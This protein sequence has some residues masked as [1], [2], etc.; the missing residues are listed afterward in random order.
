MKYEEIAK[1]II[2]H[3]GGRENVN[4]LA[5][6]ITRLRFKLKDE[7]KADTDY[8]KKR[9]GIVT[10][11]KSGGQYQVVIGNHV[12]DV[13]DAVVKVGN[14]NAEGEVEADEGEKGNLLNQFIDMI[15]KIFQPILGPLAATGMLKGLA[16]VLVAFG[17][18]P[19][20][21]TYLLIQA[22]GD[23]LFN[24]LPIFLAFTASKRF[25]LTPFTG[26]AIAAAMLYPSLINPTDIEPLYTLFA[27]TIFESPIYM[28]FLGIPVI[29]MSYASS[30][31]PI[32]LATFFGAKV[33]KLM[34]KIVPDVVKLFFVP[35]LTLLIVVPITILAIGP[36]ATWAA[37]L[38]GAGVSVIYNISPVIAGALMGGLWQILVM[39]GL[40]W[41]IVPIAINNL[42]TMGYDTL[43]QTV[44]GVSFAQ[45]GAII[46]I[47]M[48]TKEAKV[49]QLSIPAIISGFFG[50]TEPA[51]YGISLPMKKPFILSCVA[52]AITGAVAG[53][54]RLTGYA[55]GGLG[56]FA[57]PSAIDPSGV[58]S[59]NVWAALIV[60]ALG[61]VLGFLLVYFTKIPTLYEEP[62]VETAAP[63]AV[64][65]VAGKSTV[66]ANA[67][68]TVEKDLIASPMTGDTIG[69]EDVKDEAFSTGALGKGIAIQP[70]DGNVYA[71]ANGT[72]TILF[73][74]RHAIGMTTENG[75]EILI[76]IGMD[77]VQLD[78]E[79]FTAHVKQGD[80]VVAGQLL[81]TVD[82]EKLKARGYETITPIIVTNTGNFIDI[83][84]TKE[85]HLANG[86]YLLSV[87]G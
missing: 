43:L 59:F 6:C 81:L 41:G 18:A 22:A 40:H 3:V 33:E 32:I 24:F 48:K 79:G 13:Y 5:H 47:A 78:G 39:F 23:G 58:N 87:L 38:L 34:K 2:E 31:V 84:P 8:L 51:I 10:V 57:L 17:V 68:H 19:T 85:N 49:R 20:S 75:T 16:A 63:K 7:S 61:L 52:G 9:E 77:T 1:D 53:F 60:F 70:V 14:L 71:P 21:G 74:T 82:L 69:L 36:I 27:G 44:V 83:L 15:S 67:A 64:S 54:Y 56:I 62:A 26:M 11:I 72:I 86:D 73:P 25:G 45:T 42:S 80:K 35:F 29:L 66:P 12:P 65:P 4:S 28:T 37:T 55:M 76:H 30:V 46:A 50:V